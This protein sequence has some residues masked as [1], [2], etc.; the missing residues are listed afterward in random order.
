MKVAVIFGARP[1]FIKS[2]CLVGFDSPEHHL[3]LY[4]DGQAARRIVKTIEQHAV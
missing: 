1:Q 2:G 3:P 4:G